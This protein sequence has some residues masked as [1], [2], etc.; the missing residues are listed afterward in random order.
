MAGFQNIYHA[1]VAE[2][3]VWLVHQ[4][5]P[6]HGP[7]AV[8]EPILIQSPAMIG[9]MHVVAIHRRQ[10]HQEDGTGDER[11]RPLCRQRIDLVK[12]TPCRRGRRIRGTATYGILD[13]GSL[14]LDA[15]KLDHLAPFLGF[16]GYQLSKFG[17]CHRHGLAAELS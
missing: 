1:L 5:V 16:R 9:I 13:G 3:D 8:S 14:R 15:R 4:C 6:V 11:A 12:V 2:E 10:A 7:E 17:R